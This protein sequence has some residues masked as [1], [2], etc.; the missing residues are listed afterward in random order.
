MTKANY[1]LP[2]HYAYNIRERRWFDA[3]IDARNECRP[4]SWI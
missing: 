4:F 3:M 2:D 1:F